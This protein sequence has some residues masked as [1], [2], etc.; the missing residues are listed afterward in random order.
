VRRVPVGEADI[1][2]TLFTE[3]RGILSAVARSARKPSK[4]LAALEPMHLLRVSLDERDNQDLAILVETSIAH[5][6]LH[7]IESLGAME[8]AGRALRWIRTVAP[9]GTREPALF[10]TLNELLDALDD[11]SRGTPEP[12]LATGGLRI[13]ADI[14]FALV[15]DRCVRCG[16][17]CPLDA[18]A[19]LDPAFGGLVCR[20]CGGARMV[21]RSDLRARIDAAAAGDDHAMRDEDARIVIDLVDAVIAAHAAPIR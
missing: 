6:R 13:L 14:G 8:A 18:P 1:I 19:C 7:L 17:A 15:L 5:P 10:A 12:Q 11:P 4:R 9:P 21:V 3:A 16:R 2:V 20:A